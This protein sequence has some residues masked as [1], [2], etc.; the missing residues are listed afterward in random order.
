MRMPVMLAVA[1]AAFALCIPVTALPDTL[2]LVNAN[3]KSELDVLIAEGHYNDAL[4]LIDKVEHQGSLPPEMQLKRGIVLMQLGDAD[5]ARKVFERLRDAYPKQ[6]A[7][8]VNLAAIEARADDLERASQN[9]AKARDLAP[10]QASTHESLGRIH[11]GLAWKSFKLAAEL[12]PGRLTLLRKNELIETLIKDNAPSAVPASTTAKSAP[13][14]PVG[15]P[16]P[17]AVAELEARRTPAVAQGQFEVT[18]LGTRS[19]GVAAPVAVPVST[20][21][22]PAS[23]ALEASAEAPRPTVAG[24]AYSG[25]TMC[26]PEDEPSCLSALQSLETWRRDWSQ[27]SLEKYRT[28][29][30]P[31]YF[32]PQF[33]SAAQ[34]IAFKKRVFDSAGNI[35]VSLNITAVKWLDSQ[36][37]SITAV[38]R[39]QSS[40]YR[41]QIRKRFVMIR[42]GE[43]WR[44]ASEQK[45]E[46]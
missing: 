40:T 26:P 44:L 8:Y 23:R 45:D 18:L 17:A 41:D 22:L 37:L 27:R 34:W 14:V 43:L 12:D 36:H 20:P 5:E 28:H 32:P 4:A 10:Q 33:K 6:A 39:Y 46:T 24:Q 38:Q 29:Y 15:A 3:L 11:L 13:P 25:V 19:V 7:P 21:P 2:A 30:L 42:D 31:G 16:V 35:Q 9:L 1:T